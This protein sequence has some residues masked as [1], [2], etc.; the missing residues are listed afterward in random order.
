MFYFIYKPIYVESGSY[1]PL[2]STEGVTGSLGTY[3]NWQ[4]GITEDYNQLWL[5]KEFNPRLVDSETWK[6]LTLLGYPTGGL[7]PEE[8]VSYKVAYNWE[9]KEN[10]RF[11]IDLYVGDLPDQL[12]NTDKQTHILTGMLIRIFRS[13]RLLSDKLVT[14][15]V[16]TRE[17]M[18]EIIPPNVLLMYS[19]YADTYAYL[20]ETGQYKDR[21]DVEDPG[22]MI[23]RLMQAA[24]TIAEVVKTEYLD[25]FLE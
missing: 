7:S 4:L 14:A 9:L 11:L 1:T 20:V 12:A 24:G 5:V 21:T 10:V 22:T 23:P 19:D 16:A 18:D 8:I 2:P 6:G 13:L 17:E 25:K 15:G 3:R